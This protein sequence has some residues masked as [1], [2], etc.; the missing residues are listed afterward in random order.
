MSHYI[1]PGERAFRKRVAD[2]ADLWIVLSPNQKLEQFSVEIGW[3]RLQRFPELSMRPSSIAPQDAYD[4][5]EY[6]CR[7]GEMVHG[8]DYWWTIEEF[9]Q[10]QSIEELGASLEKL[11]AS[12]VQERLQPRV[13]EAMDAL[14]KHGIP[15]LEMAVQRFNAGNASQTKRTM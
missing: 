9:R 14:E 2:M 6:F 3:S 4:Q 10:A 1:W 11:S 5:N 15:Y 7:L 13:K 12:M 8:H